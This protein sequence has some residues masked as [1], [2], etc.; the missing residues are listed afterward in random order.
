MIEKAQGLPKAIILG[1]TADNRNENM[2]DCIDAGM[3]DVLTKPF[4]RQELH[5]KI[6]ELMSAT[7]NEP[8]PTFT[9][10]SDRSDLWV[11]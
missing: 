1:L 7:Q 9:P 8:S 6:V 5:K 2:K 3:N 11:D 4:R 10:K